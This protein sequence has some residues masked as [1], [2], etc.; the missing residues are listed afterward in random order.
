M[1]NEPEL[2]ETTSAVTVDAL[3]SRYCMIY[4]KISEEARLFLSAEHQNVQ[5]DTVSMT[6]QDQACYILNNLTIVNK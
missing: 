2:I 3:K 6:F 4:G 1:Q 5:E